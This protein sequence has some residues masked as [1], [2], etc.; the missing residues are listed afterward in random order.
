MSGD[1]L[2]TGE[3]VLDVVEDH[4]HRGGEGRVIVVLVGVTDETEFSQGL[5]EKDQRVRL[6]IDR[7]FLLIDTIEE[8]HQVSV[9]TDR[10]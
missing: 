4:G 2:Q 3:F 1:I 6:V 8:T 9:C 10:R 7:S 5:R